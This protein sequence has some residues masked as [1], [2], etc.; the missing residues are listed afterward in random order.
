MR[1][2]I[3]F[4]LF[5]IFF[6]T[7][8]QAQSRLAVIKDKDIWGKVYKKTYYNLSSKSVDSVFYHY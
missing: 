6:L 8:A 2:C 1:Y 5:M 4:F 7:C 3:V